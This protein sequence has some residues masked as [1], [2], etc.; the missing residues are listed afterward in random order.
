MR[1]TSR[2]S[3]AFQAAVPLGHA[4][5]HAF[6]STTVQHGRAVTPVRRR[7][8]AR[9]VPI[10]VLKNAD[11]EP[12]S[13]ILIATARAITPLRGNEE[14]YE[15]QALPSQRS[16]DLMAP[17]SGGIMGVL[18]WFALFASISFGGW[19]GWKRTR[20]R[21]ERLVSEFGEVAVYYG[22]TPDST[23][24]IV[25][26]YKRKL[27]PGIL[28]GALYKSYIKALVT[29]KPVGPTA[30]QDASL[31]KRLLRISDKA[32]VKAVNEIGADLKVTSPSLLGKLLFISE[33]AFTPSQVA[34]L[35]LTSLFPYEAPTVLELQRN[36][37]ERCYKELVEREID[38][39]DAV[40]A[41]LDIA[42]VL[43]IDAETAQNVYESVIAERKAA[44]KK[45]EE[46]ALAAAQ[47]AGSE[48]DEVLDHPART[49]EPAKVEVHAYQCTQCGYTMFPAAGREF[50][51]YGDDF[52]CP[53]CGAP[54][55][56]FVDVNASDRE[57]AR[58]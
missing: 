54:K 34:G 40:E 55:E 58:T 42:G 14:M 53:S 24:Q 52:V 28:R 15:E 50:K 16:A 27:G 46:E 7:C 48:V 2:S 35:R 32:A 39:H 10:S 33:R 11:G 29:E 56:K 12:S 20:A 19:I 38:E 37:A 51:F 6:A 9:V 3:I 23:R 30:I 43:K 26:E 47:G 45:A 1:S 22:T 31:V 4:S 8:S 17:R 18:P 13:D 57:D 36:M 44:V 49:D 41:P 21:Q 5:T 25:S